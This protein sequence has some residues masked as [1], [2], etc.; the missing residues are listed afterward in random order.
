MTAIRKVWLQCCERGDEKWCGH[1][2][3]RGEIVHGVSVIRHIAIER[4]RVGQLD[5]ESVPVCGGR[6]CQFA[7][8][9]DAWLRWG[10]GAHVLVSVI[11]G[12]DGGR[13]F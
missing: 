1:S 4:D 9:S 6:K 8:V 3:V 10:G 11:L 13:V 2:A 7:P 5:V 12:R